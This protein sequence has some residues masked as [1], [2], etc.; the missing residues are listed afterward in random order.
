MTWT[1]HHGDCLAGMASLPDKSVDV[2]ITDPPYSEFTHNKNRG[3]EL[4]GRHRLAPIEF[5]AI[6][7]EQARTC[8]EQFA[9][10][11]RRWTLIWCDAEGVRPWVDAIERA[12]LEHVRVGAWIKENCSPQFSGDRPGTGFEAVCIAHPSGRKRWN[13]GGKAAIWTTPVVN[14]GRVERLHTTQKPIALM[15]ALTRDF[16][17]PG[18]TIL[19]PFAGSGTTGVAAIRLGRHFIGWEQDAKYHAAATKRL[20]ETREQLTL[21]RPRKAKQTTLAGT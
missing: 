8:A 1:L 13:G 18:E 2:V 9:R 15:E 19:D 6:G 12:G 17:D 3:N 5:A 20:S 21:D 7:A 4:G 11:V 14:S 10:I 16:T